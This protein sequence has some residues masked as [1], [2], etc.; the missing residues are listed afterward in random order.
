M[1]KIVNKKIVQAKL[2]IGQVENACEQ[3][4]DRVASAIMQ[5][6]EHGSGHVEELFQIKK[7]PIK[8][9]ELSSDLE[10]RMDLLKGGGQ[11]LP[12][13][14]RIFFESFFGFDFSQVRIHANA[15]AAEM[16][17]ALNA[18]AFTVGQDVVFGAGQYAPWTPAGQRLLA[19][20][21]AHV[22]QQTRVC[23]S[24]DNRIRYL[25]CANGL[26]SP[27][28]ADDPVLQ[29]VFIGQR[30]LRKGDKGQAVQKIQQAL[31]DLGYP[32][33]NFGA[34]G[35]FGNETTSAV[36]N[37][38]RAN[39]LSADGIVGKITMG[40]LDA[41]FTPLVPPT[42]PSPPTPPMPINVDP[43]VAVPIDDRLRHVM[44][45]LVNDYHYPVNG[46]AGIV[47]NLYAE[48]GVLPSRIEG[49]SDATPLRSQNFAGI[50]TDFSPDEV[51]NRN[52]TTRT[53]PRLPGIGLAQWTASTRRAGLFQRSFGGQQLGSSILFNMDAQVDYLVDEVRRSYKGMN[54]RLMSQGI[55]L[56]DASDDV[57]YEYEVPGSILT[58]G[59]PRSKL[60]RTDPAVQ[61][62]FAQRRNMGRRALQ[63]YQSNP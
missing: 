48:S 47:G 55:T 53:G 33:P 19:H 32:L 8:G 17:Q 42:P 18:R 62:V 16:A 41:D 63:A 22:V 44:N 40:R 2:E 30:L 6:S 25:Q 31:M 61:R 29:A 45:L 13:S 28:F 24:S 59:T 15:Q 11:S 27:R 21:L 43:W 34:D 4:A 5:M 12:E 36:I 26:M 54:A 39:G 10:A 9:L 60:P 1:T 50:M 46:A 56:N 20:E 49:S 35:D 52:S 14:T 23:I 7:S 51:M 38:Q 3:E 57:V 37:Y 58:T